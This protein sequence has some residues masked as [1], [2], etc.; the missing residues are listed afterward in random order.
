[1]EDAVLR[2]LDVVLRDRAVGDQLVELGLHFVHRLGRDRRLDPIGLGALDLDLVLQD[3]VEGLFLVLD[4][5]RF[6][7]AGPQVAQYVGGVPLGV[8]GSARNQITEGDSAGDH[9]DDPD[10]RGGEQAS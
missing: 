1:D 5:D 3:E 10:Q 9:E 4:Q 7:V 8:G 6:R 2:D